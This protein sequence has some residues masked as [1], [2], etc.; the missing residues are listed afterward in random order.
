LSEDA[1]AAYLGIHRETFEQHVRQ[2]IPPVE[3]G[4]RKLWD[5]KALDHWLDHQSG[6]VASRR[7]LLMFGNPPGLVN[8]GVDAL[9]LRDHMRRAPVAIP[10]QSEAELPEIFKAHGGVPDVYTV[11]NLELIE[12]RMRAAYDRFEQERQP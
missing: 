9:A 5:I 10:F 8:R 12:S 4:T 1:A 3:I 6:L 11:I 7:L 2:H